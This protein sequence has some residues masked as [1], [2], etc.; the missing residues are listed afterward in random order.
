MKLFNCQNC[1]NLLFFENVVCEKCGKSLGYLPDRAVLTAMEPDEAAYVT[2][3]APARRVRLCRNAEFDACNW[4]VDADSDEGFCAACR[5]NR[6]IPPLGDAHTLELWQR[7]EA[8]K[9]RLF[10]SLI[11]LNIALPNRNDDPVEGLV[12]D[13]LNEIP[14]GPRVLTGHDHGIITINVQEAD[15]ARREE[16]RHQMHETYRTLLGHFRHEVGHWIW[17]RLVRDGGR[18]DAFRALFGDER[19]DYGAALQRH[20]EQGPA[21]DWQQRTIS[22]YATSHPWED[23]A[24]TWA[25]YLHIMDTLETANAFGM[26]VRPKVPEAEGL[27]V[28]VSI[29]PYGAGAMDAVIDQWVP[30]VFAVN[31]LN[32]SM[33]LADLYPF[34]I[35]PAVREKLAFIHAML[36]ERTQPAAS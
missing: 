12:F 4:L 17:D 35:S 27:Q 22:A 25:H 29:D 1:G 24:E 13:F 36:H 2:L 16:M 19:D 32:R 7:L 3:D 14:G 21:P 33:G 8:A 20:Y 15:D 9:H 6:T 10:Y 18:L 26:G 11:R 28:E 30:L 5:H 34:V 23:F 31:S